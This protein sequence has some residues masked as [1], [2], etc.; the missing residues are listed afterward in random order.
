MNEH[1]PENKADIRVY[2]MLKTRLRHVRW[3][4]IISVC[5]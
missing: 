5:E 4:R 1:S 2:T 3:Q